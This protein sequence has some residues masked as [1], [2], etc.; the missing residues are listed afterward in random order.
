MGTTLSTP[1]WWPQL[2]WESISRL[3]HQRFPCV[4]SLFFVCGRIKPVT[5]NK[6]VFNYVFCFTGLWARKGCDSRGTETL[7]GGEVTQGFAI[8]RS[9][10][11]RF[12]LRLLLRC[13]SEWNP[14]NVDLWPDGSRSRQ[15]CFGHRHLDQYGTGGRENKKAEG[16]S[17]FPGYN[18]GK[19]TKM[20][21][22]TGVK[23]A[24]FGYKNLFHS[25]HFVFI[26]VQ[27]SLG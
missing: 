21:S 12:I 6:T 16:L 20:L 22:M 27:Y 24:L 3:Q 11:N 9:H 19:K 1:S 14:V 18:E 10:V 7:Q 17:R 25:C 13:F 8:G 23:A 2:S 15:W 4:F 26:F 5:C